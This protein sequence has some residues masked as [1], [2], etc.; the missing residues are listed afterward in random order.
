MEKNTQKG[1]SQ[2]SLPSL[3]TGARDAIAYT[4]AIAVGAHAAHRTIQKTVYLQEK[5]TYQELKAFRTARREAENAINNP[6][7]NETLEASYQ[8][9]CTTLNDYVGKYNE[10]HAEKHLKPIEYKK[11]RS[12]AEAGSWVKS[13]F[14]EGT[15][16]IFEN[17]GIKTVVDRWN[18]LTDKGEVMEKVFTRSGVALAVLLTLAN[19]KGIGKFFSHQDSNEETHNR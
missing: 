2:E 19:I 3:S 7:V 17:R 12:A 5:E 14:K 13:Y 9:A 6:A 1:T 4:G 11:P 15:R 16:D 10:T 18:M 8:T